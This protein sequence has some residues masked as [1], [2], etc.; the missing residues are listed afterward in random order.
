MPNFVYYYIGVNLYFLLEKYWTSSNLT[1][2]VQSTGRPVI[3]VYYCIGL[4]L[5]FLL[6]KYRT[7]SNLKDVEEQQIT[8]QKNAAT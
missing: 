7:S 8:L 1:S 4:K 2:T 3:F 6:E 5:C